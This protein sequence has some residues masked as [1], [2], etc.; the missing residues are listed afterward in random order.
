MCGGRGGGK[1]LCRTWMF[2]FFDF[3]SVFLWKISG[4]LKCYIAWPLSYIHRP[5]ALYLSALYASAKCTC[6]PFCCCCF[7]VLFLYGDR[8]LI[9]GQFVFYHMHFMIRLI[10][11]T[12]LISQLLIASVC[13]VSHPLFSLLPLSISSLFRRCKAHL[14]SLNN[15]E[16]VIW[17][18]VACVSIICRN[19][20]LCVVFLINK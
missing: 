19:Y 20:W 2:F 6:R 3:I 14:V 8:W 17:M 4:D 5:S 9:F 10:R 11:L 16:N 7:S 15:G 13:P 12:K 18:V 1:E